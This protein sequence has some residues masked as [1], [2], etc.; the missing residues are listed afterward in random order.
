MSLV[1]SDKYKYIFF[2]L[3][4]NAGVY[5]SSFLI[6]QEFKLKFIKK[7]NSFTKLFFKKKNTYYLTKNYKFM[8]FNS[9]I[10]CYDFFEI[11]NVNDF[12]D[13]FMFGVV[14]NPFDRQVSRYEYSKMISKKFQDFT[15]E[16]FVE[17]DLKKNLH[18]L[19]QFEFL[20]INKNHNFIQNFIKFENLNCELNIISKKLFNKE[21]DLLHLNKSSHNEYRKYYNLK[22][23]NLIEKNLFKDLDFFTYEF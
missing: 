9:H 8:Q 13:Y 12:K 23:R 4:K 17:Y 7:L 5:F 1:I 18:V 6:N 14:R 21:H 20:K 19:K 15:F 2:H 3:P 11:F 10:T 16:E 22:T